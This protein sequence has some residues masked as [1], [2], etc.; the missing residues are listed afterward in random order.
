MITINGYKDI[1]YGKSTVIPLSPKIDKDE[2]RKK[3]RRNHQEL[4]KDVKRQELN[5]DGGQNKDM[6]LGN[7]KKD[8]LNEFT[9]WYDELFGGGWDHKKLQEDSVNFPGVYP[10]TAFASIKRIAIKDLKLELLKA[11]SRAQ[12]LDL[13]KDYKNAEIEVNGKKYT[14]DTLPE[15]LVQKAI[16]YINSKISKKDN[17][18]DNSEKQQGSE[19]LNKFMDYLNQMPGLG[20]NNLSQSKAAKVFPLRS[21]KPGEDITNMVEQTDN[22]PTV[23]DTPVYKKQIKPFKQ[24]DESYPW[25]E[26]ENPYWKYMDNV[27]YD[28]FYFFGL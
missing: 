27:L 25:I 5:I 20:E 24:Y 9:K 19:N 8:E 14:Y 10:G 21:N 26:N 17:T 2:K 13:I 3:K 12:D 15:K 22:K 1:I 7:D 4:L 11:L 23:E 16:E 6:D 28:T 18:E